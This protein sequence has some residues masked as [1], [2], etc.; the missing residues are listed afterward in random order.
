MLFLFPSV[1]CNPYNYEQANFWKVSVATNFDQ[2]SLN[3]QR[4]MRKKTRLRFKGEH[5]LEVFRSATPGLQHF[6]VAAGPYDRR[7]AG[8]DQ[9]L[10]GEGFLLENSYQMITGFGLLLTYFRTR[11]VLPTAT[12]THWCLTTAST[13]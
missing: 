9:I 2:K 13:E 11:Y 12:Q 3:S 5:R 8:R 6:A 4:D 1:K 7:V 10:G